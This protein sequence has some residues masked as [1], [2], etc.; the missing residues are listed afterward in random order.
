M[1][2]NDI[3]RHLDHYILLA[4]LLLGG[5]LALL[6]FRRNET[7]QLTVL[8]ITGAGYVLWGIMHHKRESDLSF[9]LVLEYI[10][11]ALLTIIL[12]WGVMNSL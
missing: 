12:V 4:T 11:T 8:A 1:I 9:T 7:I 5:V 3:E 6:W 2:F 10:L